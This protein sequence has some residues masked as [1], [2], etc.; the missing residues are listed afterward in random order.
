MHLIKLFKDV[1]SC[2]RLETTGVEISIDMVYHV[3]MDFYWNIL[4]INSFHAQLVCSSSDPRSCRVDLVPDLLE[5]YVCEK[6]VWAVVDTVSVVFSFT[7]T[8]TGVSHVHKGVSTLG[9]VLSVSPGEAGASLGCSILPGNCCQ[10]YHVL[11]SIGNFEHCAHLS[12]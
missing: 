4:H 2:K 11:I 6:V 7:Q 10:G 9:S 8:C 3:H 1:I 12:K 5:Y